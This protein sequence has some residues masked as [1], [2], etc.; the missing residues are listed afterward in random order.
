[1]MDDQESA[2]HGGISRRDSGMSMMDRQPKL[3]NTLVG[4]AVVGAPAV[5]IVGLV[6]G[7]IGLFAG[8]FIG[9]GLLLIASA[10]AFGLFAQAVLGKS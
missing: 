5:G 1:M 3:L 10:I 9:A 8:E 2:T 4:L 7:F 6:A